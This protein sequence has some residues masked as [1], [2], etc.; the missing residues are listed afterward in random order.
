MGSHTDQYLAKITSL[1]ARSRDVAAK[2][3]MTLS[4]QQY[5]E[6]MFNSTK[7]LRL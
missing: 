5:L 1:S 4:K 3:T 6:E 2:I 7:N